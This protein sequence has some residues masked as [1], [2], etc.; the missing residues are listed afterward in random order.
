ML[1]SRMYVDGVLRFTW[2]DNNVPR[3]A[4]GLRGK[5]GVDVKLSFVEDE[6][7]PASRA[8]DPESSHVAEEEITASGLRSKQ[9]EQV[10]NA[11]KAKPGVTALELGASIDRND[12]HRCH[13]MC[14]RRLPDLVPLNLAKVDT[15]KKKCSI[16]GR[17]SQVW[18]PVVSESQASLF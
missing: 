15:V 16:S 3:L 10:L 6:L 7:P 2:F 13:T 11:L 18:W 14:A 17:L 4:K 12:L 5:H 8:H 9:A 1:R